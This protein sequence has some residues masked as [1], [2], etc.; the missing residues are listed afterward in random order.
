VSIT[1]PK[2]Q[3]ELAL[4]AARLSRAAPNS[5]D[6]FVKVF[7]A[8]VQLRKDG[9][10]QAPADKVLLAQ[11]RAQQCMELHTLFTEGIKQANLANQ[12]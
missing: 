2:P 10:V 4:V 1:P 11:G 9:C 7:A 6:D 5:W 8:Y 12:K 3:D